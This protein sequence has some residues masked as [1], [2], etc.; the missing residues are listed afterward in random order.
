MAGKLIGVIGV[1]LTMAFVYL[2]GG[3]IL[4][5]HFG[6]GEML[7]P[8]ILAMFVVMEVL[9]LMIFG[10]IFI[11]I[12]AA[13]TDIKDTQ[14]LLMP[15]MILAT[16]PFF[17]L[18]PIMQDPNGPVA[19]AV[20]FFPTATPMLLVARESVPPG[21]PW[22]E[23]LLGVILVLTTT[24]FCL[25]AAGRVFRIGILLHGKGPRIGDLVRWVF[26]G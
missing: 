9:A 8:G 15:V 19:R 3:L 12:G 4:A 7:T 23:M 1:S 14:T 17:A 16:I 11:A 26:R 5:W 18:G 21:V 2:G 13:A 6:F 10:S 20:S 25:W 22:W 24:L